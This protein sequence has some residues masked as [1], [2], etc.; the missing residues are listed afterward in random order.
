[1]AVTFRNL[2]VDRLLREVPRQA[3]ERV[4]AELGPALD[5]AVQAEVYDWPRETIR[6]GGGFTRVVGSP[7]DIVDS[8]QLLRSRTPPEVTSGEGNALLQIRWTASYSGAVLRGEPGK[9]GRDWI[10]RALRETPV[11]ETFA[12]AYRALAGT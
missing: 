4:G 5:E 6:Y 11:P 8:G 9:P 12:Q 7:R 3:L 1:M 2:Q 10:G